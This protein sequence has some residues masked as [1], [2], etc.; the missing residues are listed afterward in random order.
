MPKLDYSAAGV[1]IDA[2]NRTVELIKQTVARTHRPQVLAGIGSFGS[3]FDLSALL[4]QY[5]RPVMV[6]SIDG[7]GTKVTVARMAQSY[8][9]LGHDVV[10]AC[11]N[12]IIVHG[13]APLTFLDY[14]ANQKLVPEVVAEI[15]SGMAEAC[16]ENGISLVG[17][18]TA[19][20]PST[21]QPSEHDLVGVI[22]GVVEYE[23][24]I[25]GRAVLPG[26]AVIGIHSS[27]LH[28]NGYSLARKVFFEVGNFSLE[29]VLPELGAPLGEVLLRPHLNYTRPIHALLEKDFPITS[30]AHITGGGLLENIPRVLPPQTRVELDLSSWQVPP[31]FQLIGQLAQLE[32]SDL[33]RTFNMGIGMTVI[34]PPET[35]PS[36]ISAIENSG[37]FTASLIGKTASG[38]RE[39]RLLPQA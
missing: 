30:I 12:D 10:S 19:E 4:Q 9:S 13:A 29:T 17:G 33:F 28:T 2:G 27:G 24:I 35:A 23:K 25:D 39:V 34:C 31:V 11:C 37:P 8:R 18:E 21:Y 5:R 3:F 20:M 14:I 16:L 1:D 6:Q 26:Q 38:N 22:T 36:A 7:V 15:V 32:P